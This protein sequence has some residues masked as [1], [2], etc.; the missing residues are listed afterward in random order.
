MSLCCTWQKNNPKGAGLSDDLCQTKAEVGSNGTS[1]DP[2]VVKIGPEVKC[3]SGWMLR[4][5]S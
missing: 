3:H 5:F 2:K 1:S 4:W